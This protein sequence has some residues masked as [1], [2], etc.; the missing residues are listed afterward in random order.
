MTAEIV[1]APSS[2]MELRLRLHAKIN[3]NNKYT[4]SMTVTVLDIL[5]TKTQLYG[6]YCVAIGHK[7]TSQFNTSIIIITITTED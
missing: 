2:L 5:L 6:T 3:G 7:V 4:C 1:T